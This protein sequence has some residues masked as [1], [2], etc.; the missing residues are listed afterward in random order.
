MQGPSIWCPW[1]SP[2]HYL[3]PT[4][5]NFC[6]ANLLFSYCLWR[7][8]KQQ[9]HWF[10]SSCSCH[11]S[12]RILTMKLKTSF[13]IFFFFFLLCPP[14]CVKISKVTAGSKVL[15]TP[16]IIHY[17]V[18]PRELQLA[19]FF[20]TQEFS[21]WPDD[22]SLWSIHPLLCRQNCWDLYWVRCM[23]GLDVCLNDVPLVSAYLIYRD[24]F[25]LVK[26]KAIIK[27]LGL[28]RPTTSVFNFFSFLVKAATR[29][30]S[31]WI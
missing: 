28:V 1:Y 11:N 15:G 27:S 2:I 14:H 16:S 18:W 25:H 6:T 31:E 30:P 7:F 8:K 19:V 17:K 24:T 20:L 4:R 26:F 23:S 12:I 21:P 29:Q 9:Q 10:I 13:G 3:A 22:D 5:W